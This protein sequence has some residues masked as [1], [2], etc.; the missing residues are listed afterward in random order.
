[1][2]IALVVRVDGIWV[3]FGGEIDIKE[4]GKKWIQIMEAF[5]LSDMEE[6]IRN[7]YKPRNR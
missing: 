5:Y 2:K 1:M 3:E 7:I 6:I 4:D